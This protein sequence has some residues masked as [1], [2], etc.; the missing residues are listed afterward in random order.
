MMSFILFVFG[1]IVGSFLN[2]CIYRLP[3][4]ESVVS[5]GSHCGACGKPIRWYDNLPVLSYFLLRGK[6]R[7][8]GVSFSAQHALVEFLTGML[9]VAFYHFFGLEAMGLIY[10][11]F[12]LAV[13]VES[14]IDFEHK[15][16]PD[17]ITLSGIVLGIILSCFFPMMHGANSW[18]EGLLASVIGV[19]IGGGFLYLIAV[20]AEFF[21][22][23]EAMGG[24]DVKLL[25]MFGAFLGFRGVLW[26]LMMGSF[27]GSIAGIYFKFKKKEEQIPFGPFLGLGAIF[28]IF[29]GQAVIAWYL[30]RIGL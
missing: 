5:P 22:K 1:T 2:V 15:I 17:E 21:L 10:L 12:T 8:C 30:N 19:F 27:A 16:I 9:F 14:L 4:N 20:I 29:Y 24:G 26:A 18:W 3:R 28:Y 6:C 7:D 11:I 25:A 13:L 23:K